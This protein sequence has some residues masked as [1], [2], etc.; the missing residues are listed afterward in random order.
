MAD[1]RCQQCGAP[2]IRSETV[3]G[4]RQHDV[5]HV[6]PFREFGYIPGQNKNY[7]EA[8]ATHNLRLLCRRCHQRTEADQGNH[9]ALGGIAHGLTNLAPLHL[10]CDPRDITA[11]AEL[12]GKETNAPTITIFERV[13]GGIGLSERLYEVSRELLAGVHEMIYSCPCTQGCPGCIGPVVST[14]ERL[15]S[16]K[17]LTLR[18]AEVL[19]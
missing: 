8:N 2:E 9:T 14:K 15:V 11:I 1:H 6:R 18:L 16:L 10:M 12:R 4:V 17:K 13:A 19:L 3:D 7:Q 5:H